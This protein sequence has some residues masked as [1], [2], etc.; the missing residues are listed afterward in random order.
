MINVTIPRLH[1]DKIEMKQVVFILI[2]LL[3]LP[4]FADTPAPAYPYEML[5]ENENIKLTSTPFEF[6]GGFGESFVIEESSEDTLYKL[7]QYLWQPTIIDD[8]GEYLVSV[9]ACPGTAPLTEITALSFFRHGKL[10]KTIKLAEITNDSSQFFYSVS[11]ISWYENCEI[12][13][14]EFQV[15]LQDGSLHKFDLETGRK[16]STE[17]VD[18]LDIDFVELS[19]AY[20]DLIY[21]PRSS[22]F[23]PL[24]SSIDFYEA[25][26]S[27]MPFRIF[28]YQHPD[29]DSVK[30]EA[31]YGMLMIDSKGKGTLVDFDIENEE[32]QNYFFSRDKQGQKKISEFISQQTFDTS[33]LPI[34]IPKW[35]FSTWIYIEQKE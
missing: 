21:Y 7:D 18:G 10:Y 24:A 8:L 9:D 1:V 15:L 5:S 16:I 19:I 13:E 25:F 29:K 34:G 32:M 12:K 35:V 33:S 31:F 17:I 20:N 6:Y 3:S 14:K 11:H 4:A 27:S 28:N 22:D 30:T 23:P 2:S 26:N